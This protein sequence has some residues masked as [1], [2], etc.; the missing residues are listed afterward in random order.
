MKNAILGLMF[1]IGTFC[2]QP[3][4][5]ACDRCGGHSHYHSH[6][7]SHGH[8]NCGGCGTC[9]SCRS[10][11]CH[12]TIRRMWYPGGGSQQQQQQ[13]AYAQP[14]NIVIAPTI[15]IVNPPGQQ[16]ILNQPQMSQGQA[17]NNAGLTNQALEG[18]ITLELLKYYDKLRK[19]KKRQ[20]P[21]YLPGDGDDDNTPAQTTIYRRYVR[22]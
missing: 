9:S 5:I 16:T 8:S 6:G 2:H 20:R 15:P 17:L 22:N 4:S 1:L 18:L 12:T 10:S 11:S 7:H 19:K 21:Y 3:T 14:A 13:S